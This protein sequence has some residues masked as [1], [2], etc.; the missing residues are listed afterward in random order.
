M[1]SVLVSGVIL[2]ACGSAASSTSST[3]PPKSASTATRHPPKI[4]ASGTIAAV[5]PSASS[6]QVQGTA[7]GETTVGW[8]SGTKFTQ[9]TV[10]S[11]SSLTV[12]SCVVAIEHTPRG[13][14]V[15]VVRSI[16]VETY[17]TSCASLPANTGK[18]KHHGT[19]AHK[20]SKGRRLIRG[21][22]TGVSST[23]MTLSLTS[24]SASQTLTLPLRA[25][26]D[27]IAHQSATSSDLVVGRCVV[28]EGAT[29]SIGVVTARRIGISLP[30]NGSCRVAGGGT[31]P[32]SGSTGA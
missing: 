17:T 3:A 6:L 15:P 8:T 27:V 7:T 24:S 13:S 18:A 4:A 29:N 22:I 30:T 20:G 28:V 14:R 32:R 5:S 16:T 2:A 21:R 31:S 11:P 19:H 25:T 26:T 23:S 10:I 12:G 9:T 1:V